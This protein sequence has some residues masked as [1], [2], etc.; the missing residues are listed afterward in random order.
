MKLFKTNSSETVQA[1]QENFR[2]ELPN[3]FLKKKKRENIEMV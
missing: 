1:C 2:F 3:V